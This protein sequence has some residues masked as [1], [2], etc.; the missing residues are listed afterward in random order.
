M[1]TNHHVS[2]GAIFACEATVQTEQQNH[3]RSS[4]HSSLG[5]TA[6]TKTTKAPVE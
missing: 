2:G 3:R 1:G 6:K 4:Y 5:L